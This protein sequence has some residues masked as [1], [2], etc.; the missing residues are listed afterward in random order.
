MAQDLEPIFFVEKKKNR[1]GLGM[2]KCRTRVQNLI[3]FSPKD[4]A[5]GHGLFLCVKMSK[6]RHLFPSNY[7]IQRRI[8]FYFIA[9][10]SALC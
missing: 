10:D 4:G 3:V 9:I 7:S 1:P 6:I 5:H 8:Q 2:G